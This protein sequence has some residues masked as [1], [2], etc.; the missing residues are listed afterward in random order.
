M[1]FLIDQNI[2]FRI[3]GFIEAVLTTVKHVK[4]LG[5][6]DADDDD[7]IWQYAKIHGY[8]II[9]FD[10]DFIDL[11]ILKDSPPKIIWLRF[12]NAPTLKIA[13]KLIANSDVIMEFVTNK[14]T[15]IDFLEID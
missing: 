10:S 15:D 12:G 6:V 13:N 9:T 2:S 5:L 8:T 7:E 11:A 14:N 1:R 3:V 4:Q